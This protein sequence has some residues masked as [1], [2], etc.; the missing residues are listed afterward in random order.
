MSRQLPFADIFFSLS[1]AEPASFI[2]AAISCFRFSIR[3]RRYYA[4]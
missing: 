2:Y 3:L 4:R 1:P